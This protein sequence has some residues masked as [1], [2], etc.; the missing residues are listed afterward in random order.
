MD[1]LKERFTAVNGERELNGTSSASQAP[2]YVMHLDDNLIHPM[3]E[4]HASEYS[5]GSGNELDSKMK[6]IRSS[7]AMTFNLLGNDNVSINDCGALPSGDYSITYEYQLPTL[8]NNPNPANLDALLVSSDGMTEIYCE[9]KMAEW[10]LGKAS[11]LRDAYL[12]A[13]NYLVPEKAASTFVSIFDDLCSG[14][15]QCGGR[16]APR[17]HRYDAFQMLKHALAIYSNCYAR[18]SAK[19][20]LPESIW[21][22]NCVWEMSNPEK[23]AKYSERYLRQLGEEHS[24]YEAFTESASALT[25]LFADLGISFHIEYLSFADFMNCIAMSDDRKSSLERYIV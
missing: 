9:M 10:I 13:T 16:L 17:L 8:S 14:E 12:V 25:P 7:S 18:K 11:G 22:V 19:S 3:S 24:Q 4:K 1:A 6:S 20:Q 23:L 2:Y 5:Q 21:L 15:A